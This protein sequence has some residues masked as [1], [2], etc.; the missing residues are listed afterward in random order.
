MRGLVGTAALEPDEVILLDMEASLEHMRRGTARHAEVLLVVTEP[1]FRSLETAARLT[2]L[3]AE[4]GIPRVAAVVNKLR[5][6]SEADAVRD[7]CGRHGLPVAA[8]V[9]FDPAVTEVDNRGAALMDA[10]PESIAAR[11][12]D[13]LAATLVA[14]GV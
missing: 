2:D 13:R 12:I 1:Y 6:E 5:T 7:F 8:E 14:G 11:R 9:P 10:A 4:L 3:A